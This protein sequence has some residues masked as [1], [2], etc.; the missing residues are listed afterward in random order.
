MRIYVYSDGSSKKKLGTCTSII[1]SDNDFL[2]IVKEASTFK[3]N[4]KAEL[5][6]VIN[7]LDYIVS[8]KL[9]GSDIIVYTDHRSIVTSFYNRNTTISENDLTANLWKRLFS[10][11]TKLHFEIRHIKSHQFKHN[12]NKTCDILSKLKLYN[13][14]NIMVIYFQDFKV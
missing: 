1:F 11:T 2:G 4:D 14:W 12:A 9:D 3:G 10:L 5:K 13:K 6:G 8:N 7:G